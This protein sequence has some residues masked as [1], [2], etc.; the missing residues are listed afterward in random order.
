MKKAGRNDPCPCGSGKKFKKCC[1]AKMT[2]GRFSATP[3]N[4]E[5][6]PQIQRTVGLT[7][8]FQ[9]SLLGT[10]KKTFPPAAPAQPES[11]PEQT[12]LAQPES[13]APS[14]QTELEE[15]GN[16]LLTS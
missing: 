10:P 5:S 3:V 6:A 2:R 14:A 1:E 7:S 11:A 9:S 15:K 4:A 16:H 13:A 12:E 8:L